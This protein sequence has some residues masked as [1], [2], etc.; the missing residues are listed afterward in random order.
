MGEFTGFLLLSK[1]KKEMEVWPFLTA[2]HLVTYSSTMVLR[3]SLATIRSQA[4]APFTA[5]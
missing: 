1:E 3:Y 5:N 2:S 4:K